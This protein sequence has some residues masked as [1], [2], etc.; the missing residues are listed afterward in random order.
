MK[1]EFPLSLPKSVFID[2]VFA[3]LKQLKRDRY[4]LAIKVHRRLKGSS[5]SKPADM[6]VFYRKFP[7]KK[8]V[9]LTR[10]EFEALFEAKQKDLNLFGFITYFFAFSKDKWLE[11][12]IFERWGK[13]EQAVRFDVKVRDNRLE[14]VEDSIDILWYMK[15]L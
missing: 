6:E 13:R 2:F 4:I 12:V 1:K 7:K 10:E 3:E 8:P 11:L 5:S 9:E 14:I 15:R